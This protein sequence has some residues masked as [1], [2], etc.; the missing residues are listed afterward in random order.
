[1]QCFRPS[2]PHSR[3]TAIRTFVRVAILCGEMDVRRWTISPERSSVREV[4]TTREVTLVKIYVDTTGITFT[5]AKKAQPK[6]DE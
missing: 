4:L 6:V 5:V 1:M 3:T 2:N